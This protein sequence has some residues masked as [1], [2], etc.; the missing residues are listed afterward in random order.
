M[1]TLSSLENRFLACVAGIVMVAASGAAEPVPSGLPQNAALVYYQACLFRAQFLKPP[2]GGGGGFYG[3]VST[4]FEPDSD[5]N[6]TITSFVRSPDY[7]FLA[8]LVTAAGKLPDCDWGLVRRKRLSAPTE[9]MAQV[10]DLTYFLVVQAKVLACDG[11]YRAALENALT[12][13]R[14]ARHFGDETLTLYVQAESTNALAFDVIRYVLGKMPPDAE[15][16]TWLQEQLAAGGEMEWRPRET[17]PKWIDWEVQC[18]QASPDVLA[19]AMRSPAFRKKTEG[20]T[21]DQVVER[22]RQAWEEV[23]KSVLEVLESETSPLDKS[24]ALQQLAMKASAKIAG[25]E[26]VLDVWDGEEPPSEEKEREIKRLMLEQRNN[27]ARDPMLLMGD[28]EGAVELYS[29]FAFPQARIHAVQAAIAVYLIKAGT[30][31]LPQTLPPDL[32]KDPHTGKDFVYQTTEKG[33]ILRCGARFAAYGGF[34]PNPE[35]LHLEFQ[36]TESTPATPR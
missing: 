23:F 15:T 22:A 24:R 5:P 10:R 3:I 17:L 35:P 29:R 31:Q 36:V 4:T 25:A 21:G 26:A 27:P 12:I 9:V 7:K 33:F 1:A 14:I 20:L 2:G 19:G 28:L 32:P 18:L 30:G 34:G 16:L 13:R 11:Q 6:K 8:D